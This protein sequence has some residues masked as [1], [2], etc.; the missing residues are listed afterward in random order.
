MLEVGLNSHRTEENATLFDAVASQSCDIDG[1]REG[2]MDFLFW[3]TK[4]FISAA[5]TADDPDR[6]LVRHRDRTGECLSRGL[7]V[8]MAVLRSMAAA[9]AGE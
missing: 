7:T 3:A 6:F 1:R 4:Y 9:R 5:E 2:A 8:R